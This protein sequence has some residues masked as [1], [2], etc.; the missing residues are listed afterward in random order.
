MT[1]A[2]CAMARFDADG[3]IAEARDYWHLQEGH[4]PPPEWAGRSDLTVPGTTVPERRPHVQRALGEI[5]LEPARS[6]QHQ[7]MTGLAGSQGTE[8][9]PTCS[10]ATTGTVAA[11]NASPYPSRSA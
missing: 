5:R 8:V 3:L 6:T 2:G 11:A 4:R 7:A 10:M 9:L 1:L